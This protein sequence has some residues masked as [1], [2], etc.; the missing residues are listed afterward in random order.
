MRNFI[1]PYKNKEKV[2]IFVDKVINT[3]IH[4]SFTIIFDNFGNNIYL[5]N[6]STLL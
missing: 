3:L 4:S 5:P 1:H 2:V 6:I